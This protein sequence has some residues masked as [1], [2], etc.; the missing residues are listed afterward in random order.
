[1]AKLAEIS[2][3]FYMSVD[4]LIND[5][6]ITTNENPIIEDKPIQDK[7][8][9]NNKL[10]III[11]GLLIVVMVAI[12]GKGITTFTAL[13]KFNDIANQGVQEE[14]RGVFDRAFSL[15]DKIFS[16][17]DK[18]ID[19]QMDSQL[20]DLE[21][22][23]KELEEMF[24][25]VA[26]K[27]NKSAFNGF[28]EIYNGSNKGVQV[29][30][31]LEDIITSNKKQDR[32]ITIKYLETE[33]QDTDKIQNLK[34]SFKDSNEFEVSFDYDGEGYINKITIQK[35]ISEFEVN[36][37]N[38]SLE[39]YAGSKNGMMVTTVLDKIITSNKTEDRRI[40]VQYNGKE[41]QDETEIKN[42]KRNFDTFDNCEIT[43][44]YDADGFINKII[45]EKL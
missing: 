11:V 6:P 19:S 44:E 5:S 3:I 13:N 1:M 45:I 42:I 23:D 35:T 33:T 26:N 10:V 17:F 28:L 32:K 37:F 7:K 2:K 24:G 14:A 8:T 36:S 25:N 27:L 21:N 29:K 18:A 30:K 41:T 31:L 22:S 16:L 34:M 40:T 9:K 4:D 38:N 39:L 12:I 15:F 20:E 43:Y